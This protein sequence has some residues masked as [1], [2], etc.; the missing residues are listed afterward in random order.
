MLPRRLGDAQA[1]PSS[2]QPFRTR[3][4]QLHRRLGDEMPGLRRLLFELLAQVAHVDAQVVVVFDMRRSPHRLAA[5]VRC[6]S[7]LPGV[8]DQVRQQAVFDRA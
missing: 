2:R 6:V 3:A 7:T 8:R 5:G 4:R 1:L